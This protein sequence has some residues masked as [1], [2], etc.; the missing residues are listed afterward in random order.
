MGVVIFVGSTVTVLLLVTML[1]IANTMKRRISVK[2]DFPQQGM[3]IKTFQPNSGSASSWGEVQQLPNCETQHQDK[4]PDIIKD[5]KGE[6]SKY[7][8]ITS[9]HGLVGAGAATTEI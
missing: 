2:T 1:I 7:N 8:A 6:V 3:Q 4:S 9:N 5:T